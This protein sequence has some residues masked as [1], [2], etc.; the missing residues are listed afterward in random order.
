LHGGFGADVG[1]E[2]EE[3]GGFGGGG[4]GGSDILFDEFGDES[5]RAVGIGRVVD[6]LGV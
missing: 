2:G 5:V 1:L 3:A 4:L 6:Y